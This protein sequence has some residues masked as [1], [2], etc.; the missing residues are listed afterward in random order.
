[1]TTSPSARSSLLSFARIL[2]LALT[3]GLLAVVL[4]QIPAARPPAALALQDGV[5]LTPPMGWNSWYWLGCN[6]NEWDVEQA[7]YAMVTSGMRDT[8]YTYVNVDDCWQGPRGDDGTITSDPQRFPDGIPSVIDYVHSLG[9]KFGLYTDAGSETCKGMPGSLGHEQ[10]DANTDAQW[11][12]DFVKVDWCHT[13]GL[14]P[15][16]QYAKMRDALETAAATFKHPLVLSICDWGVDSPWAWGPSAGN[17]WRTAGDIGNPSDQWTHIIAN[18]DLN[19]GHAAV[20]R[21]GAWN[22]PDALQIGL[23][24]LSSDEEKSQ[25]TLWAIMAAPLLTA[26]DLSTMSDATK[27]ILT[28]PYVI[29]IDQ[30]PA[31]IQGTVVSQ[32]DSGQLQVWAKPLSGAHSYAVALFN[33]GAADATMHVSWSDLGLRA[34]AAM[35][36]NVWDGTPPENG[37][38]GYSITVPSHGV[39]LL[40]VSAPGN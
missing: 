21:P 19:A 25:I 10:Q 6:V 1:M 20:A 26:N 29:A 4:C 38:D 31:G 30:D 15:A 27:A 7:A 37:P 18:L 22:D 36:W 39:A 17:M 8:G 5:A 13:D 2:L 32:D 33:R 11:G 35:V 3:I 28:N 40:K 23:G 16:T 24:T 14:D 9:L 12:V 34:P